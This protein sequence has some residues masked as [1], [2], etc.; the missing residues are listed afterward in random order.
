[1]GVQENIAHLQSQTNTPTHKTAILWPRNV[2][3]T[4]TPDIVMTDR[5]KLNYVTNAFRPCF[6]ESLV[7][8]GR[9]LAIFSDCY[10]SI[11]SCVCV[12]YSHSFT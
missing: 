3:L 2:D 9:N 6:N 12:S 8:Q 10:I 5:E 11:V 1:M 4:P 7:G